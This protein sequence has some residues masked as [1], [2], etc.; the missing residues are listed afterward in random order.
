MTPLEIEEYSRNQYNAISDTFWSSDEIM[1]YIYD[2]SMQ[3]AREAFIIEANSSQSTVIS[4]Q[5]YAFPTYAMAIKR[6]T[7]NGQKLKPIDFRDDDSL[8]LSLSTSTAVGT[9]LYYFVWNET[10][11]LRPIP[12]AIGT[13]IIRTYNEPTPVTSSSTLEVPT[14]YHLDMGNLVLSKMAAKDS[15]INMATYYMN[16]WQA[17]LLK[18]RKLW[19]REKR[20]DAFTIVKDENTHPFTIIGTI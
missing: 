14:R 16:L 17:N 15:N 18:A 10:L 3:L 5:E 11:F 20:G 8:T 9:P 2:A 13:L 12:D 4:Q 19:R 7:Y 6:I 1:T